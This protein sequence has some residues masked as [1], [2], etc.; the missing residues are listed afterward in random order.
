MP[1]LLEAVARRLPPPVRRTAND[2]WIS[3]SYIRRFA[4]A[5]ARARGETPV[6]MVYDPVTAPPSFG[7]FLLFCLLGRLYGTLGREVE[8]VLVEG[9][10]RE[11]FR[12]VAEAFAYKF[13]QYAEIA[14][15]VS[16]DGRLRFRRMRFDELAAWRDGLPGGG[17]PYPDRATQ[18]ERGFAYNH[19]WNVIEHVLRRLPP[20]ARE[21]FLLDGPEVA[22]AA[23]AVLP[24]EPYVMVPVR[25]ASALG[26]ERDLDRE[27]VLR[28]LA[29]IDRAFPGTLVCVASDAAGSEVVRSWE[30]GDR[31]VL[32]QD[33]CQGFICHAALALNARCYVQIQG[34]GLVLAPLF[35]RVP[36]FFACDP[37]NETTRWASAIYEPG[38]YRLPWAHHAT[39]W[40]SPDGDVEARLEDWLARLA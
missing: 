37:S 14:H 33:L 32:A 23:G 35:S 12:E 15:A 19:S 13:E 25:A 2:V 16:P 17:A 27:T 3:S 40:T 34:G 18:D 9:D 24:A 11:D 31:V 39:V 5:L 1:A 38:G 7:D 29:A 10:V 6:V 8:L 22:A 36:T 20:A 4:P 26:A 21:R 28:E 30:L